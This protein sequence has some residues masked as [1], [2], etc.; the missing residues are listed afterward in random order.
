MTLFFPIQKSKIPNFIVGFI[1]AILF[2]ADRFMY[3]IPIGPFPLRIY[4]VSTIFLLALVMF[5]E[6][7]SLLPKLIHKLLLVYTIYVIWHFIV[8]FL[9]GDYKSMNIPSFFLSR[10]LTI[11]FLLYVLTQFIKTKATLNLVIGILFFFGFLNALSVVLQQF[12]FDPAWRLG[13]WFSKEITYLGE[14]KYYFRKPQRYP[15][16]VPIGIMGFVVTTGYFLVGFTPMI[17]FFRKKKY[18]IIFFLL[19]LIFF[20]AALFSQQRSAFILIFCIILAGIYAL[21][22]SKKIIVGGI[23]SF[24]ILLLVN[25]QFLYSYVVETLFY[26]S[27]KFETGILEDSIRLYNY[28]HTF[29]FINTY[30]LFGGVRNYYNLYP[31][32]YKFQFTPHNVLLNAYVD[33]GLIGFILIFIMI[34]LTITKA[35]GI[36]QSYRK[37]NNSTTLILFM[38]AVGY[39]LNSFFHSSGFTSGDNLFW[40]FAI[41][42][43]INESIIEREKNTINNV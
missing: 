20:G 24:I 18:N 32:D 19:A 39:M 4:I 34:I 5:S 43:G 27:N 9:N 15:P 6:K 16:S 29:K 21:S 42:A 1:I 10:Y 26:N 35:I 7:K 36:Y 40:W 22:K 8:I 14:G 11:A 30:P 31:P 17:F 2:I 3:N 41:L 23:A 37:S 38:C 25:I 12:Q 13:D 33:A 28:L